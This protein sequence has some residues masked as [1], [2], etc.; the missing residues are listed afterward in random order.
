MPV[1]IQLVILMPI[2][3]CSG[4]GR[5]CCGSIVTLVT[6]ADFVAVNAAN[7]TAQYS[8]SLPGGVRAVGFTWPYR[9]L[10]CFQETNGLKKDGERQTNEL[11]ELRTANRSLQDQMSRL[12]QAVSP[13]IHN[14]QNVL[15]IRDPVPFWSLDQ[16]SGMGKKSRSGSGINDPDH[17]S[18]N[19]ETIFLG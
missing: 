2:R 10:L 12:K 14:S 15:R 6:W 16:G 4:H 1:R 7:K 8:L 17:I 11:E 13:Y 5:E 18:D 19:L 3:T 9:M